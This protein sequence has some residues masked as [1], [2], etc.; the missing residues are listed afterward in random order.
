MIQ[1]TFYFIIYLSIAKQDN[2]KYSSQLNKGEINEEKSYF[3]I[4]DKSYFEISTFSD[5]LLFT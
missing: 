5:K 4:I 2:P 3:W 1:Q